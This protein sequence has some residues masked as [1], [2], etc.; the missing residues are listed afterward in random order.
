MSDGAGVAGEWWWWAGLALSRLA[1]SS[2]LWAIVAHLIYQLP[3]PI[4]CKL[5]NHQNFPIFATYH[6]PLMLKEKVSY[7]L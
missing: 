5:I 4:S 6:L 2:L 3:S 7:L 1:Y